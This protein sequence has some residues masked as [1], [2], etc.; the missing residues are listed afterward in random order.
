MAV[1]AYNTRSRSQSIVSKR[2]SEHSEHN[3]SMSGSFDEKEYEEEPMVLHKA[4]VPSWPQTKGKGPARHSTEDIDAV[5]AKMDKMTLDRSLDLSIHPIQESLGLP[6]RH[7]FVNFTQFRSAI[8]GNDGLG[9]YEAI[10]NIVNYAVI[11]NGK[12]MEEHGQLNE[13]IR[14]LQRELRN[15]DQKLENHSQENSAA[16]AAHQQEKLDLQS[17]LDA[18]NDQLDAANNQLDAA[19]NQS[20]NQTDESN[21]CAKLRKKRQEHLITGKELDAALKDT[22]QLRSE[23]SQLRKNPVATAATEGSVS[24]ASGYRARSKDPSEKFTGLDKSAYGPWKFAVKDKLQTDG[25]LYPTERDQV[26]YTYRQ[27][28]EPIFKQIGA[29][30]RANQDNLTMADLFL[31]I[32]QYMGI[33]RLG[34]QARVELLKVTMKGSESIDEY[35]HRL[36]SLWEDAETPERERMVKF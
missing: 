5:A 3:G 33:H 28:T 22:T 36:L 23:L 29:W 9:L 13:N 31:E 1:P 32:K 27:V 15:A 21:I 12:V 19:N 34:D 25:V 4:V 26:V 35:Y 17:Q 7:R 18:A 2:E 16:Q 24:E 10:T 30:A 14:Y 11:T 20:A 8:D 6:A